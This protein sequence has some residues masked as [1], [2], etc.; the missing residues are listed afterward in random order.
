M[1]ASL[2]INN[3]NKKLITLFMFFMLF[4]LSINFIVA[5][6]S[7]TIF[8]NDGEKNEKSEKSERSEKKEQSSI[9]WSGTMNAGKGYS[10][11]FLPMPLGLLTE[12][13]YS[14]E[15]EKHLESGVPLLL[16]VNKSEMSL[17]Q[18][19]DKARESALGIRDDERLYDFYKEDFHDLTAE[20]WNG[21]CHRWS[22][23]SCDDEVK[24]YV[25]VEDDKDEKNFLI[26]NII[27]GDTLLEMTEMRELFTANYP[28]WHDNFF[29]GANRNTPNEY[30][31]D[32]Y[33]AKDI[34]A[35]EFIEKHGGMNAFKDVNETDFLIL[36]S[37]GKYYLKKGEE[38]EEKWMLPPHLFHG[39][40]IDGMK[41]GGFIINSD[42][43]DEL[44]N[45]PVYYMSSKATAVESEGANLPYFLYNDDEN[46]S[47]SNHFFYSGANSEAEKELELMDKIDKA[48]KVIVNK[49][50]KSADEKVSAILES[51][52]NNIDSEVIEFVKKQE[53]QGKSLVDNIKELLN[54]K[55][56]SF[57]KT[58]KIG[59]KL[60]DD[61]VM[62]KVDTEIQFMEENDIFREKRDTV[63]KNNYAYYV[64][65]NKRD[66][67][68]YSNW[69]TPNKRN[70]RPG[71]IW[72]PRKESNTC[73]LTALKTLEKF[74]D[75]ITNKKYVYKPRTQEDKDI[76]EELDRLNDVRD[77][78]T[79]RAL[80]DQ[81]KLLEQSRSLESLNSEVFEV[82]N[83][84]EK[85][86]RKVIDKKDQEKAREKIANV[87]KFKAM[88]D[89]DS[90][91][92]ELQK[93]NIK[94]KMDEKNE[95]IFE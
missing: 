4:M 27:C 26:K 69:I 16:K 50:K 14:S 90:L 62:E 7:S 54:W 45:Q 75:I 5:I 12:S 89:R 70:F 20:M 25:S 92:I 61:F 95:L 82:V 86:E 74:K 94:A 10:S 2:I 8:A 31:N 43:G 24:R 81:F 52:K 38:V 68:L 46:K 91:N 83:I 49:R 60:K 44:W 93:R 59:L 29:R 3:K 57:E 37:L 80:S 23:A 36:D 66:G 64:V 47:M 77:T 79:Q 71:S 1:I 19:L 42:P 58:K 28:S 76:I 65:K 18:K 63:V 11:T 84:L 73:K 56:L 32:A 78:C 48:L 9:L 30:Y 6:Y 39:W 85:Y 72:Y 33:Y 35:I 21:M 34:E 88:I 40:A 53:L 87:K 22:A 13:K 15:P 55:N 41:R 51:D 67:S 17:A